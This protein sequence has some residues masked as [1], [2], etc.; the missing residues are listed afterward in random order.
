MTHLDKEPLF[1]EVDSTTI[2]IVTCL[3]FILYAAVMF[4]L[5]LL[6]GID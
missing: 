6:V 1:R 5:A 3:A 2:V 4:M